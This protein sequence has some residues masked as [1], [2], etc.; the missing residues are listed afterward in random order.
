MNTLHCP[1]CGQELWQ[2]WM[3]KFDARGRAVPD[4]P[5]DEDL[6]W[7][8]ACASVEASMGEVHVPIESRPHP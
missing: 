8:A 1:D 6:M 5:L 4:Y 3:C 7:C 2:A